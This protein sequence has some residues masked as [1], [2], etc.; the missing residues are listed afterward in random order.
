[1]KNLLIKQYRVLVLLSSYNGEKY[2]KE[3]IFSILNQEEVDVHLIIR[4]DGSKDGTCSVIESFKDTRISLIKS[5]NIG[6][7]DSFSCL[8]KEALKFIDEYDYFAFSDQDDIWLANK[9][10]AGVNKLSKLNDCTVPQLYGCNMNIVDENN[11]FIRKCH[12]ADLTM[13]K[14]VL[15]IDSR[16]P[17]CGMV[18]NREAVKLYSL[19]PPK[20]GLY[21][22]HWMLLI[23]LFFGKVLYDSKPYINY[24]QHANNVLG[25]HHFLLSPQD[26][27]KRKLKALSQKKECIPHNSNEILAFLESFKQNMKDEDISVINNYLNYSKSFK[28]RIKFAFQSTYF[29]TEKGLGFYKHVLLHI[30]RTFLNRI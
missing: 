14:G 4:D 27:I 30:I 1:M 11:N 10:I 25:A 5:N 24:R 18:F 13:R 6:C 23:G 7:I 3:Q 2:I 22:D 19:N 16:I 26:E 28:S 9:L 29:P 12:K 21:H 17:G 8:V 15:L 20:G